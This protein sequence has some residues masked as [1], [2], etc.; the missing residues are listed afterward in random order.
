MMLP[1]SIRTLSYLRDLLKDILRLLANAIYFGRGWFVENIK[2]HCFSRRLV[3]P[4]DIPTNCS[5]RERQTDIYF[6][7]SLH[8]H[9][10]RLVL[11]FSSA[12]SRDRLKGHPGVCRSWI[13]WRWGLCLPG[14]V[15]TYCSARISCTPC[16]QRKTSRVRIRWHWGTC[17]VYYRSARHFVLQFHLVARCIKG[18]GSLA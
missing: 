18:V 9:R 2:F 17:N 8:I 1:D 7:I 3:F 4:A 13:H 12:S 11:P 14:T 16:R 5:A 6:L 15:S 10:F